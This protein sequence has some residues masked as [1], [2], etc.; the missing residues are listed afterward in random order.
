M[1]IIGIVLFGLLV[2]GDKQ[3]WAMD[4]HEK[5]ALD[6]EQGEKNKPEEDGK[7]QEEEAEKDKK[8]EEKADEPKEGDAAP[9]GGE[10]KKDE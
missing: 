10:E 2:S 3:P 4:E 6:A 9:E 5:K 1:Y 7:K 8:D